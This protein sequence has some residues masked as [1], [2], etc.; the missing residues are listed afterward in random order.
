MSINS[1]N[2]FSEFMDLIKEAPRKWGHLTVTVGYSTAEPEIDRETLGKV[3][4][5]MT[6]YFPTPLLPLPDGYWVDSIRVTAQIGDGRFDC[7]FELPLP[8]RPERE[9]S[10]ERLKRAAARS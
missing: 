8:G 4:A 6:H 3:M 9:G 7:R 1:L 5:A 10:G 2:K